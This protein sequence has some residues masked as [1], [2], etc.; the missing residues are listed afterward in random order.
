VAAN[1]IRQTNYD[2]NDERLVINTKEIDLDIS[3]A[4]AIETDVWSYIVDNPCLLTGNTCEITY[5]IQTTDFYGNP[6]ELS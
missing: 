4:S 6:I 2:V 5:P 1:P 3:I